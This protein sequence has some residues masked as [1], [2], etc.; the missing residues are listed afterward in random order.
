[1]VKGIIE[2]CNQS[3]CSLLGGETAEMPGFYQVRALAHCTKARWHALARTREHTRPRGRTHT[4]A[5]AR[6]L[7]QPGEYDLAGFAVG[8]VKKEKL[9]NG[10]NIKAGDVVLALKSSGVHSNGFSLVRKVLEVSGTKLTDPAPWAPG[11]T[12]GEVRQGC[13]AQG[14][15]R[16]A[17]RLTHWTPAAVMRAAGCP[18][19]AGRQRAPRS[20]QRTRRPARM[21]ARAPPC[22]PPPPNRCCWCPPSSTS[23]RLW[24]CTRR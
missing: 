11:K 17:P 9:I 1:M 16:S 5:R 22:A 21:Q 15:L 4:P 23:R 13:Q 7:V 19:V 20:H 3:G 24:R 14:N 8:A 18:S 12:I 10:S 6:A 2:G